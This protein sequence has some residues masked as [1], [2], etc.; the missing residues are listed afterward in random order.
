MSSGRNTSSPSNGQS[1]E[2]PDPV[3]VTTPNPGSNGTYAMAYDMPSPIVTRFL[4][5]E[6][7]YAGEFDENKPMG[8]IKALVGL[9][10]LALKTT[11]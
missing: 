2:S 3:I 7:V 8:M 9:N 6:N 10:S 1:S 4:L 11:H 5:V